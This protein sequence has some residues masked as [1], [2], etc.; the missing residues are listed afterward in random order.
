ME[1]QDSGAGIYAGK[2]LQRTGL[3]VAIEQLGDMAWDHSWVQDAKTNRQKIN[4]L[5]DVVNHMRGAVMVVDPEPHQ[6]KTLKKWH[7][8]IFWDGSEWILYTEKRD[9]S[10]DD[11]PATSVKRCPCCSWEG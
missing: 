11:I 1:E 7:S 6:C 4:E 10:G 2:R 5:I 3:P 8:H 9:C